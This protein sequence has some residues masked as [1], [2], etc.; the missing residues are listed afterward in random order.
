MAGSET[1]PL[2]ST[3]FDRDL[4]GFRGV[5]RGRIAMFLHF[6]DSIAVT[7]VAVIP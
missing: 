4:K 6:L 3:V 1:V 7:L 5:W 2:L